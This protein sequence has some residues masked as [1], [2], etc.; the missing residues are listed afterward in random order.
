MPAPSTDVFDSIESAHEYVGLLCEALDEAAST[1]EAESAGP[2]ASSHRRQ[3]DALHLVAFKLQT[4]R[5]HFIASRLL[6][7]DLRT[8]RRYLPEERGPAREPGQDLR[9]AIDA[10]D[11][12][13]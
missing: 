2:V 6:L 13:L 11:V 7:N 10:A 1:V 9:P 5:R 4:L 12:I 8:L 3:K